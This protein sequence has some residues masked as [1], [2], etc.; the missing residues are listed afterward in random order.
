M[1]YTSLITLLIITLSACTTKQEESTSRQVKQY[2]IEQFYKNVN[3][4][5]G[6]FS[7][8]ESKLLISSNASGIYN[9]Y[10]L[11]VDGSGV[12]TLTRNTGESYFAISYFPNDERILF[13]ADKGG[14]EINHIY[15]LDTAGNI[16]DLTPAD[17][18]KAQ[19]AGWARDEKS[20]FYQS[21]KRDPRFFDLYE[22][23]IGDMKAKMMYENKDGYFVG[24]ISDDKRF[25]A[26]GKPIS[27]SVNELYVYDLEKKSLITVVADKESSASSQEFSRDNRYL[28]YTT[29]ADAEFSYLAS[30]ELATGKKEKVFETNWDVWYAYHSWNNTYRIIG[31]NEDASTAI[32]ITN[33][34]TGENVKAPSI[35]GADITAVSISKSEKLMRLTV[36]SS[37]APSDIY[38]YNFETRDL[39]R[40]T[41]SLN[42]EIDPEDLVHGKVVRYASYDGVEIPS[43]LYKPHVASKDNKVPVLVWVHGGPGGQTRLSYFALLQYLVNNGYAVIGVNNRGSSGYG[44]TFYRMDDKRHGEDDLMDCIKAK[45]YLAT[46][47]WADTSKVGIIGGSYGGY[48]VM[49]ALAF[50]PD[51]FD[52]GVNIFGVTN[53]LRTL[54]SIPSWWEAQRKALYDELGDPFTEDSVRLHRISPLF[55]AHNVTKPLMVLQGANDPRVLQVESDE[56]VAAVRANDVPVEYVLF[57]DEGHGF[58]KKENEIKGYGDIRIFLDKYLKGESDLSK[59]KM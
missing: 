16:T 37:K 48:M 26:L 59:T 9:L 35:P 33:V 18:E 54:K 49:A 42:P 24:T 41:N 8:D 30:Y 4:G 45:D 6:S 27:T 52:V 47:D 58:R 40:L 22:F 3:I 10:A 38:V 29:D 19:F 46:L 39:K 28:Y 31:I 17:N 13:T 44:K 55:H 57:P 5:G 32:R 11:R 43:I 2:S 1:R 21:N 25:I 15:M 36:G 34:K 56:I 7:P 12:D 50:E 14:N 20:F 51:A 53:W 23:N